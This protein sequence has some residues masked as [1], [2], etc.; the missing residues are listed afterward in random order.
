[1]MV[2]SSGLR[3]GHDLGEAGAYSSSDGAGAVTGLPL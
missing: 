1:M 3:G 2:S